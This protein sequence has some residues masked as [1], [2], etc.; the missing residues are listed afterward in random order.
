[1]TWPDCRLLPSVP[2]L[3]TSDMSLLSYW[4][5][6][7]CLSIAVGLDNTVMNLMAGNLRAC[8]GVALPDSS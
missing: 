2:Q 7:S 1:M 4:S 8:S 3:C 5:D 6:T